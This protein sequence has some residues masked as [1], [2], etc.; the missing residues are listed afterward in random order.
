MASF[1]MDYLRTEIMAGLFLTGSVSIPSTVYVGLMTSACVP[2][3]TGSLIA[4]RTGTT[5]LEVTS[6][7][8]SRQ[9]MPC[10]S[11]YWTQSPSGE[12]N[13]IQPIAWTSVGWSANVV[14]A[15]IFDAATVGNCLFYGD[16]TS[17][18]SVTA[19]NSISFLNSNFTVELT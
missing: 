14:G 13:N 12:I 11:G 3:D 10:S 16:L 6:T 19:G 18:Q 4:A 15:A 2:T 17:S 7:S 8:Y 1:M 9:S 5:G